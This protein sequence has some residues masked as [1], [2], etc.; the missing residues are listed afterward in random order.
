MWKI[1]DFGLTSEGTSRLRSTTSSGGT[2]CYRA[3]ELLR[4]SRGVYNNKTDIWSIGCV[5]YEIA[6]GKRPFRDDLAVRGYSLTLGELDIYIER[7]I[8]RGDAVDLSP[9]V[10]NIFKRR[11]TF[12]LHLEIDRVD[13]MLRT[14][15]SKLQ[16]VLRQVD[17]G[18]NSEGILPTS[19][20]FRTSVRIVLVRYHVHTSGM[21]FRDFVQQVQK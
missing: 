20:K 4:G 18:N 11:D 5:L 10:C 6:T 21:K 2:N 13:T 19:T 7:P 15:P 3:P 14:Q 8:A 12:L 17:F 16:K 1:T 9:I